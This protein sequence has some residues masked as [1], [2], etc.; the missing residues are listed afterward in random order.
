MEV[1]SEI[2]FG[3]ALSVGALTLVGSPPTTP[4]A[5]YTALATFGFSF[6]ILILVWLAFS[7]LMSLLTFESRW[8]VSMNVVLLFSV[9]IEPFLF[10]LLIRPNETSALVAAANQTY[11]IDIGVMIGVLGVLAWYLATTP[12]T[13]LGAEA[14]SRLRRDGVGRLAVAGVYL[15][16]AAPIFGQ[17]DI[18]N[19]PVRDWIW[20]VGVL[21]LLALRFRQSAV[22]KA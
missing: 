20:I 1:L 10:D 4:A 6:L 19:E 12:R 11:G 9:A 15:V 16:S 8:S 14:R 5:L 21:V 13:D 17:V 18:F 3:L 2:V 22:R 7:H